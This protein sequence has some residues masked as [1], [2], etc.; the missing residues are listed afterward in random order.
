[1]KLLRKTWSAVYHI[2]YYIVVLI[3]ILI[4]LP[5]IFLATLSDKTY[6]NF[7]WW[8]RLW[9]KFILVAMGYFW[10]IK[11]L[12]EVE[13]NQP[14]IIVANHASELDIMLMYVLV[15]Q[16]FVFI[17]KKELASKPLFGYFYK[18]TNI[19]ID[20]TSLASK[21]EVLKL[22]AKKLEEGTSVC[23]FPE[24]GIPDPEYL[25]APF[26]AGAFKLA[27]EAQAPILP[28]TFPD[29]KRHF[30]EFFDGGYPGKLRAS[31]HKPISTKG[32]CE[33]DIDALSQRCYNLLLDELT[34]YGC[35]GKT[36]NHTEKSTF[37]AS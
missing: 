24:G 16:P 33:R 9:A 13:K 8:A 23:I 10:V 25:L 26:K 30:A 34:G 12:G 22:A 31:M 35:T 20:R 37:A 18:R 11:R 4:T 28:I 27:I 5:F 21:R 32:L 36:I 6:N 19:L 3:G 14:Y 2:W 17:G 1:V 7:F 15:G 29:N